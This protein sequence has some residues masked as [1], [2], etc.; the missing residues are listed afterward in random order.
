MD[1]NLRVLFLDTRPIRRGAQVFVNELKQRFLKEGIPVKRIFLYEEKMYE[2]LPLDELDVVMPFSENHFFEKI[3]TLHPLLVVRLANEIRSFVPD[4]ILCNGSRTLKYAAVVKYC[5]P[6]IKSKWIYR[7][8]DSA[9]YWNRK[10]LTKLYYRHFVIPAMDGAVGVSQKSLDEMIAHYNFKKPSVCIPRAIDI[11]HF[12]NYVPDEDARQKV[13]IRKDAFVLLFL[14]NFTSQ[15]RP[16][17]FI[18]II[19]G[20]RKELPQV[21]GLM[22]GDG[23]L[24]ND[25]IK[26]I[27]KLGLNG[28]LTLAGYHQDV[29]PWIS[30]SDILLLTSDTEGMP[31]VVLEAG[32]MK[33]PS[34]SAKVGGIEELIVSKKNGFL[35]KWEPINETLK[36]IQ[37]ILLDT[38]LVD[39]AGIA[40]FNTVKDNFTLTLIS[41]KY[42]IFFN[43]LKLK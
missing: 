17:R 11:D 12:A 3:P 35:V 33:I 28:K 31:G 10:S 8:I 1:K 39:S 36:L 7:V 30:L 19:E 18:E 4:I 43:S 42:L 22:V 38:K 15:K 6:G 37:D 9:A 23:P 34:F 21:H 29:R 32:A 24:R 14:G 13:G 40:V 20:L 26:Q 27:E 25:S 41:K 2:Q 16:D 5:Y